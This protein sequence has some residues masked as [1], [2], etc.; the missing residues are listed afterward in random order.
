M[1]ILFHPKKYIDFIITVDTTK[2]GSASNH[3]I[4][5]TTGAGYD[6]VVR[7]GDGTTSRH[8][9]TPGNI[10]HKYATSGTYQIKIRGKFPRIF[11]NNTGDKLKLISIDQWG[12]VVWDSMGQAFY[13]CANMTGN[14]TD[15]PNVT[16]VTEMSYMFA[17][18]SKFNSSVSFNT[19]AVTTMAYMFSGCSVF[20]K[21][22]SSFNTSKVKSTSAMFNGCSAFNQSVS[23]FDTA[24][25]TNMS[26]MFQGCKYF[27][28]SLSNFN[29]EKVKNMGYMFNVC[30]VFNQSVSNFNTSLVTNMESMF[31]NCK[32]F[33]QSVSNFNTANVTNMSQMFRD[34]TAFNQSVSNFITSKV[35]NISS[36]FSGCTSLAGVDISGWDLSLVTGTNST[37]NTFSNCSIFQSLT[38]PASL[39]RVDDKFA[40][41]CSAITN[42]YIY[43]STAP[44]VSGTPFDNYAKPL[45]V[46]VGATGYDVTPWTNTAI[47]SSVTADL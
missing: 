23:N 12:N 3:F 34:S 22:V 35:T 37:Q 15:L 13:G 7:W 9:G 31:S 27:N 19:S 14:Y 4:L 32:A 26:Y 25:V 41:Y 46:P 40:Q 21:T 47:F 8:T 29:T 24:L 43:R 16:S 1:K 17:G 38:L 42:Y 44:T 18:C 11:F 10:D 28:Q 36:M 20:N 39:S 33:N 45:H 2:A 6:C 5:P 30:D